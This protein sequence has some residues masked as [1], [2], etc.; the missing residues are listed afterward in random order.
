MFV[1]EDDTSA[2]DWDDV[3]HELGIVV[4]VIEAG[5]KILQDASIL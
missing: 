3:K 4:S 5:A 1:D 2:R